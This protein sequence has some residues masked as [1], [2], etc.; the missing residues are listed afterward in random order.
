MLFHC[1]NNV[2]E[3]EL[4][5]IQSKFNFFRGS[6]ANENCHPGEQNLQTKWKTS[7]WTFE[8]GFIKAAT[9]ANP[10]K[11]Y[12]S[13]KSLST[14]LPWNIQNCNHHIC[15]STPH[16]HSPNTH[17]CSL[18]SNDTILNEGLQIEQMNF[19]NS[20][21]CNTPQAPIS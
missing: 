3:T 19:L 12:F 21:F 13:S 8:S 10:T 15:L 7:N 5:V 18:V 20:N 6:H 17:T 4:H 2:F 1:N 16:P 14:S 9:N 11:F